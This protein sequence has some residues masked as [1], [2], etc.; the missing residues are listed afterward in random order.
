MPRLALAAALLVLAGCGPPPSAPKPNTP[1]AT[2]EQVRDHAFWKKR[3]TDAVLN[4]W[5][6]RMTDPGGEHSFLVSDEA[7][8]VDEE[9]P[10]RTIRL[11]LGINGR[12]KALD[13]IR[14]QMDVVVQHENYER[15][16]GA[17]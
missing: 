16:Y 10:A 5:L 1:A 15:K 9:S 4:G 7:C 2:F 17:P 14:D 12:Q 13:W 8:I 11:R 3:P 6:D